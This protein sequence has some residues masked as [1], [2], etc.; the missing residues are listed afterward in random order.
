M[1]PL[2]RMPAD[3]RPA[4]PE[5]DIPPTYTAARAIRRSPRPRCRR[6][7]GGAAS[8]RSE[9]TELIEGGAR[10]Q[11]RHRRGDRAH[12]AGRCAG[13]HRRRAA[14]AERRS[15]RQRDPF[16]PSQTTAVGGGTGV[17]RRLGAQRYYTAV[18]QR[19]LRDRLLGQEPRG[20]AR[21]GGDRRR[22]PL[23]PRGGRPHHRRGVAN[24]YFQVLAAQDRLRVARENLQSATR[25]LNLIKQ[26]LQAG[27][28]SGARSRA[29]GKPRR[30]SSAPPS[31]RSNRRCSRTRAA[32]ALLIA[33]PPELVHS[34]AAAC[35]AIAIPRVTPGLPSELLTQRPDIREAE[36]QSRRRQRQRRECARAISS[37]ASR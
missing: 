18:A 7:T 35:A 24:A 26:R 1:L 27:T 30:H 16:A 20:A 14:A 19:Q 31:R 21:R 10:R 33:R 5:L 2:G 4:G 9:L 17:A 15:Q 11:S 13:A 22:Q 8:A 3:R 28:A 23:R 34:A 32:L 37:R 6:S 29:A 25:M 12:R 36:A